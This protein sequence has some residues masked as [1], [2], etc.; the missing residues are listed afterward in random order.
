MRDTRPRIDAAQSFAMPAGPQAPPQRERAGLAVLLTLLGATLLGTVINNALNVPLRDITGD[1]G[2]SLSSGV[3]VVSSFVLVLAAGMALSGW[4]GDRFGRRRTIIASLALMAV[5]MVGAALAPSLPVLVAMRAL[6]GMACA[7]YPPAVMGMLATIYGPSQRARTMSAWAA[8][9]GIGQAVGPPLG[10]LLADLAGW[11]AIF[12][13]L[14][15]VAVI[16][17]VAT[18][19]LVPNDRGRATALHWPGAVSLTLGAALLMT[20]A[21]AVPQPVVPAW[22]IVTLTVAGVG[23][24]AVFV[25]SSAN[26]AA[27]IIRPRLIVESRFLRSTVAASAQMFCLAATLVA[28]PLYVTGTLGRTTAVTGLLVLAL[29]AAM[30]LLAPVVGLLSERGRP[31]WILRTGLVLLAAAELLLGLY[32][33]TAARSTALL[34]ALLLTVGVG[35]ALVQTPSAAGAT[36]SPAGRSG[37]ALGLFNMMRFGG[38]ALGAAWVAVVYP[39]GNLLLLF[40]GCATVALV[41]LVVSFVGPDPSPLDTDPA[42]PVTTSG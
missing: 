30:A 38:S 41:G 14:A 13:C 3:L 8:A 7:A 6:Q 37:A 23:L 18:V 32:A 12:W 17:L 31:R 2:V 4:V 26:A 27:P 34:V 15:P 42:P 24:L 9:N 22:L 39:Y 36:R 40:A 5:A 25:T 29:P 16:L 11:R 19:L 35:V 28:V 10:G 20:A 21:T 1:L 33:G